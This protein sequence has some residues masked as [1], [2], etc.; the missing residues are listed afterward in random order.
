MYVNYGSAAG[1]LDEGFREKKYNQYY[2]TKR[3]VSLKSSFH[4]NPNTSEYRTY[5]SVRLFP[6]IN[7]EEEKNCKQRTGT[8][9][10]T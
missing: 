4:N 8:D 3:K 10:E 7:E 5:L 6:G 9:V 2:E 1:V